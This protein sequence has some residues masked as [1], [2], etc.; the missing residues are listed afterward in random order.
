MTKSNVPQ[1]VDKKR[2][3]YYVI[4]PR[5]EVGK[6]NKWNKRM[7]C[8]LTGMEP[9]YITCIED[10]PFQPKTT[11]GANKLEAQWSNDERRVVNQDQRLKSIIISCPPDDIMKYVISCETAKDTWTDLD[12]Q[13][14]YDDEVVSKNKGLVAKT[15]DWDEEEV[16]DD[17]EIVQ[18]KVLMALADDELVV[19]KNHAKNSKWIDI[20]MRKVNIILS[21]DE[22]VDWKNYL[23]YI[24]IDLSLFL[25]KPSLRLLHFNFKTLKL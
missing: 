17:E 8:Y 5:I 15:F 20:T 10:G 11:E 25:N 14:N 6:F 12:F 23:K 2:G 22:D 21:I 24:N 7:L 13:E 4:A 16:S 9:Y 19:W 1:L 3:S 18:V